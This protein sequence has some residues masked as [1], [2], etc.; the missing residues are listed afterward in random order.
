MTADMDLQPAGRTLRL[1]GE[2]KGIPAAEI[3]VVDL[4]G[5][6]HGMVRSIIR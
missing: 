6:L 3:A 1:I 2:V 4:H 5:G